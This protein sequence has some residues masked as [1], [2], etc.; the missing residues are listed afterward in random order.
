MPN[1]QTYHSKTCGICGSSKALS[2]YY[3][4]A[5]KR[6]GLC[7]Y[8][9]ECA[10]QKANKNN[11]TWNLPIVAAKQGGCFV[12]GYDKCT[13]ALEFH[14]L[15][16][17]GK[18]GAPLAMAQRP[19]KYSPQDVLDELDKCVVMCSNCHRE[20]QAGYIVFSWDGM[21]NAQEERTE[22]VWKQLTLAPV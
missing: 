3:S 15:K 6:D 9:K 20:E 19:K 16:R 12:C 17:E 8:C 10:S 1:K 7:T 5:D 14:H 2:K 22:T 4:D 13:R 11:Y 21:D 18:V